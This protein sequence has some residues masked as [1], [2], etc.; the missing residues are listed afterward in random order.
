MNG[1]GERLDD[2]ALVRL[3]ALMQAVRALASRAGADVGTLRLP[4]GAGES[5]TN[6]FSDALRADIAKPAGLPARIVGAASRLASSEPVRSSASQPRLRTLLAA[7]AGQETDGKI[8]SHDWYLPL[9]PLGTYTTETLF[10]KSDVPARAILDG[11]YREL[12]KGLVADHA[13]L[14]IATTDAYLESLAAVVQ[15]YTWCVP[16]AGGADLLDVSVHDHTRVTAAI[17]VCLAHQAVDEE[18]L[19]AVLAGGTNGAEAPFALVGGDV[20]GVQRFLYT[21]TSKGA[22]RG[23]RG[24]SFYLQ[25]LAEAVVHHL[26][27]AWNLPS[28]NVLFEGGGHFYLLAPASCI[29]GTGLEALRREITMTLLTHHR[30][31]LFVAIDASLLT[32]DDIRTPARLTSRW[33]E[34]SGRIATAKRRKGDALDPA[35]LVHELFS[36]RKSEGLTHHFCDICQE[37]IDDAPASDPG[38]D[39]DRRK[40]RL[41]LGME[42]LGDRLRRGAS[43]ILWDHHG[44]DDEGDQRLAR[45][46]SW[47][48]TLRDLGLDAV[49]VRDDRVRD[50]VSSIPTDAH[51]TVL[52]L[53]DANLEAAGRVARRLQVP[54]HAVGFRLFGQ[55]TP[56]ATARRNAGDSP[57]RVADFSDLCEA[58]TGVARLGFLRAD[59]DNL[60]SVFLRGLTTGKDDRAQDHATLARRVALSFSLR[61]FFEGHLSVLCDE[62]NPVARGAPDGTDRLYLIYSGG[63]DLFLA[64]AWDTVAETAAKISRQLQAFA[65]GN[66]A[67]HLSAGLSIVHDKYPVR[68]A[69][70]DSGEALDEAK[71]RPGKNAISIFDRTVPW[72]AL[73]GPEGAIAI[74]DRLRRAVDDTTRN[75]DAE[76]PRRLLRLGLTL[77]AMESQQREDRRKELRKRGRAEV[78]DDQVAWGRWMWLGAYALS[79]MKADRRAP[80]DLVDLFTGLLTNPDDLS[81][82]FVSATWADLAIR[83]K[84]NAR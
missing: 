25:L 32:M 75:A 14:P 20:S 33:R 46:Q 83:K 6:A 58:S 36:P 79:R 73:E 84:E 17:A 31:D 8:R 41:C 30:G 34:L 49:V 45:A 43:L 55:A 22:L 26:C 60:G 59:V 12:W 5:L 62:R 56:L 44:D 57:A 80:G 82:L 78:R 29:T 35:S 23:L 39:N 50:D 64:G 7:V 3:L 51:V 68:Q 1:G 71:N 76:A 53:Q 40:C 66:P 21:I 18:T 16:M 65:G 37:L 61:L 38:E 24:R 81:R 15:K 72:S 11:Q 4:P 10:P 2:L 54:A 27:K 70:E 13:T 63:D 28:T 52:R 47:R 19:A 69:A 67:V 77:C 9:S 42:D 74:A 48:A